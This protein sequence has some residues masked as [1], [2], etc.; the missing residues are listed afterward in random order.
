MREILF[1]GKSIDAG[2]W[3]EGLL[4]TIDLEC[5]GNIN[6]SIP[7]THC[8]VPIGVEFYRGELG[9]FEFVDPET[10]GQFTGVLD[11][12]S[13]KIFEGDVVKCEI[14]YDT[15]CYPRFE[16]KIKT[17]RYVEGCFIPLYDAVRN[18]YEVLGNI[19]DNP[20]LVEVSSYVHRVLSI[21]EG[22]L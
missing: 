2:E 22:L 19:H 8:I 11:K 1:R 13:T 15:G 20:E 3:V 7:R 17:V 14:I 6:D 9:G 18:S 12:N 4:I 5:D 10:V 21:K 16:T